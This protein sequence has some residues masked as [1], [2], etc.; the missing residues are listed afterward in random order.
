MIRK[1]CE[2]HLEA[3]GNGYIEDVFMPLFYN[4]LLGCKVIIVTLTEST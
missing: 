1:R 4:P 3:L 2:E